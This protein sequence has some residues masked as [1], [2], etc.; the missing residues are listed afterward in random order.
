MLTC[1]KSAN[2][3]VFTEKSNVR[4]ICILN[5]FDRKTEEDRP[6]TILVKRFDED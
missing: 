2:Y 6:A 1:L 4:C 3:Q 5:T